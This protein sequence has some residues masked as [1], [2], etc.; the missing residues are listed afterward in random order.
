[1][2]IR[3]LIAPLALVAVAMLT[4]AAGCSS[5]KNDDND[6]NKHQTTDKWAGLVNETKYDAKVNGNTVT[7]G[8]HTYMVT[9]TVGLDG[10]D[11]NGDGIVDTDDYQGNAS[12][13]VSFSNI[14]SGY[15]E[16]EAVYSALLG[17]TV[18]GTVGMIPMAMEIYARNEATGKKC[19][20]LLCGTKNAT[21]MIRS[22]Q[23]KFQAT[24]A[25]SDDTY[26]QR[27]LPAALLKGAK[28]DNAYAPSTP[29]TVEMTA[30]V[31]K[32]QSV[33]GG[34]DTFVYILT[35]G[36]WDTAQRQVEIYQKT[37]SDLHTVYNCPSVYT[38][39]K[40][41]VGTWDGLNNRTIY[42]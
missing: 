18:A 20:E 27:Y 13:T 2:K 3:E 35:S 6:N 33:T 21:T 14:P 7:Y 42:Y 17:K 39:C 10:Q 32:P 15:T 40:T 28:P 29:Y 5:D 38:Q 41:I 9:G 22:L 24:S 31:N 12:A 19:I 4:S 36:G 37:G 8:S 25:N 26:I 30:S 11:V 1:M 16:F 23:S 34:T